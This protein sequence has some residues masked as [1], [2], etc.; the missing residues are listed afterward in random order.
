MADED[1]LERR[2]DKPMYGERRPHL[3]ALLG[4]LGLVV[5]IALV[6]LLLTVIA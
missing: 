2:A 5:V 4:V 1:P 3:P 6:F